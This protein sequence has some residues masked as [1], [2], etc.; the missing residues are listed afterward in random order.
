MT[1]PVIETARLRLRQPEAKDGADYA[2]FYQSD[3]SRYMGGPQSELYSWLDYYAEVGHWT[4]RGFGMFAVTMKGDDRALGLV[5]PW[6]P[7]TWPEHEIGWVLW[8]EAE[9]KG[10][11][12]E[13]ATA[14]R[15]HA[16]RDLG[17]KTAVSYI[18]PENARSIRLAEALGARPDPEAA[19]PFPGSL[20]YRHPAPEALA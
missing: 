3:R 18:H 4:I 5:G 8:A 7:P 19:T 20:I 9:G 17:W 6:F 13:A 15:A 14:A 1:G 2:A 10:I 12:R 16:Y 11:A